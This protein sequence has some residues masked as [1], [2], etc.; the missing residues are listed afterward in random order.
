MVSP[1][2][3]PPS[4]DSVLLFPPLQI[5]LPAKRALWIPLESSLRRIYIPR[6]K[7]RELHHTWHE[8]VRKSLPACFRTTIDSQKGNDGG[9]R[10]Y[11]I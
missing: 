10:M 5:P 3:S 8:S 1:L 2:P 9:M 7:W 4:I 11:V 6:N